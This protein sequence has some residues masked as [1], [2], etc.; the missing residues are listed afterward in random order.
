[1][2]KFQTSMKIEEEEDDCRMLLGLGMGNGG[3]D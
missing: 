2:K 3:K 1:M